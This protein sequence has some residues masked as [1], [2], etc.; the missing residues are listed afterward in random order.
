MSS[1]PL[2]LEEAV[3]LG[4]VMLQRLLE[5]A[6]IRSLVIKGPAFVELGVRQPSRSNDIDLMIAPGD[7]QRATA[8]LAGAGWGIISHWFPPALDDVIY[9]TT[10]SHTQ[11]PA[12]LDL[13]HHFTGL[14]AD[15]AFEVLWRDR[16]AVQ[17]AR[18]SVATPRREH[19]LVVEGL[20]AI[21]MLAHDRR[22]EAARR[23]VDSAAPI[24]LGAVEAAALALGARHTAAPLI[25]A[26]GGPDSS[27]PPP[28]GYDD[29]VE[30]GAR[31][32]GRD[33][34]RDVLRRS[35]GHAPR[36]V[37]EQLTLDP[38]VARFW[39]ETH[40]VPYRS[41]QQILWVRIRRM[42]EGR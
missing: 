24:E 41:P 21:K 11:F 23:V 35:P 17:V 39:A 22:A 6:G 13:H 1:I 25:S 30:R 7:R 34:I 36:V 10:F 8:V 2:T 3:P 5:A 38:K 27:E 14:L 26:L 12:T 18:Q 28:A 19:A 15:D 20:N 33:L 4:T 9:S 42:L 16:E 31:N 37:W 40:A 32:S 29:W